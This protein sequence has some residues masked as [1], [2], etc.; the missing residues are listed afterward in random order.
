MEGI[1][2]DVAVI[3]DPEDMSGSFPYKVSKI[4]ERWLEVTV[5]QPGNSFI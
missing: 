1:R 3:L 4:V 2:G 5:Y